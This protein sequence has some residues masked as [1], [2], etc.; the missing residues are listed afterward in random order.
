[1]AA[2]QESPALISAH[3]RRTL[4]AAIM[5]EVVG[6]FGRI[7]ATGNRQAIEISRVA[8][9]ASVEAWMDR[10]EE[11]AHAMRESLR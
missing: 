11:V 7:V 1:M 10:V 2:A 3:K 4:A 8:I 5:A 9:S 6:E